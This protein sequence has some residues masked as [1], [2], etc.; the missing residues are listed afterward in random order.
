MVSILICAHFLF[1]R[2]GNSCLLLIRCYLGTHKFTGSRSSF[3]KG[4]AGACGTASPE[5]LVGTRVLNL[6]NVGMSG[7]LHDKVKKSFSVLLL[8]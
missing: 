2:H 3:I 6:D 7:E 5:V 4:F 1:S 8:L